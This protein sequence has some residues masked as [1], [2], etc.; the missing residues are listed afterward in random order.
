MVVVDSW[1]SG[2]PGANWD[3]GLEWDVTVGPSNGNIEK[4][5][6]L[7]AGQHA[8]KPKFIALLSMLLQPVADIIA[9]LE[10]LPS[11]FDLDTAVGKQLDVVGEWVGRSRTIT[12][13]L[14]GVYF[15]LGVAGLGLDEGTLRGQFDP[16]S[17]LLNLSDA[18]YRTLLRATIAAN[19][20]DGTIPGAYAVWDELF[21]AL[22]YGI[23]I[24][25]NG[26]MSMV[27]ALTGPVPDAVTLALFTGGYFNLKPAGVRVSQYLTP[28]V[29][30]APY[31]GIGIQNE[32]IAGLG[33]GAFGVI[34][35]GS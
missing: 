31:F 7:V 22:G 24:V 17:G 4:Y 16:T 33:S 2:L 14:P 20:W 28:S 19:H 9:L 12:V 21:S 6:A 34:S 1:D 11:A 10:S 35:S 18:A 25:D 32:A 13:P 27:Y 15:S 3:T 23:L 5:L 8:D 30:H 26:D 29:P